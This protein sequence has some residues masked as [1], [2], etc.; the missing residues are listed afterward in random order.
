MNDQNHQSEAFPGPIPRFG[1][2]Q[3]VHHRRY[4]YRGVVVDFDLH[5]RADEAWYQKNR[6]QPDRDQPWYHVLVDGSALVTY[7]AETSLEPDASG[8]PIEHPLVSKLFE[9]F[10]DSGY[11]RNGV[12]WPG[13]D[14]DEAEDADDKGDGG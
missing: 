3:L 7:A 9:G 1:P 4:D 11:Q 13:W 5:C 10:G 2:G 14:Q 8:E 12:P 6:T